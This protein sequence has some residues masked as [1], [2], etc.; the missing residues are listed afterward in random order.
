MVNK[1][2]TYELTLN[3]DAFNAFKSDF[4]QILTRTID[5]MERKES[6][7]AELTV[8][9]SIELINMASDEEPIYHPT[10]KHKVGSQIKIKHEK[11]G[12]LGGDYMLVWDTEMG[13]YKMKPLNDN[14]TSMFDKDGEDD[15]LLLDGRK[16]LPEAV[17]E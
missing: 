15:T 1:N 6:S 16:E 12:Y 10:F 11:S 2:N 8:K 14:Q 17:S 9:M 4:D 3:S 13:K 7:E 5:T